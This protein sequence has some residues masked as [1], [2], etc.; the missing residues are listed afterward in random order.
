MNADERGWVERLP[1]VPPILL[2]LGILESCL[3]LRSG[4]FF[5]IGEFDRIFRMRA[6]RQE[7]EFEGDRDE[8]R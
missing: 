8:G 2:I 3:F 1:V 5:S 7:Q 6:D 4:P